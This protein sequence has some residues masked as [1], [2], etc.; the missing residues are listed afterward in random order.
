MSVHVFGI[1]HHGP[2]CARCL[3]GALTALAPDI[4]LIEGPPDAEAVLTLAGHPDMKPPVALLVYPVEAPKD[5][6]FYP[7]AEFSPEWQAIRYAL[8]RKVPVRFID[9]PQSV[10]MAQPE[11][12]E[13][14][15]SAEVDAV[16]Q[17]P[18]ARDPLDLLAEAAGYTDHELWWEHQI[19][20]HEDPTGLF[21]GIREAMQ[22]V[23][24]DGSTKDAL[25]A[26]REAH[27]RSMIRAAIKEGHE[28]IA[29]VCGAWHAPVLVDHGTAKEDA[30][31]LK[32]LGKTKVLATW[33]PWTHSRLSFRSGYGAGVHSPGWYQHL[34]TA[35][36]RAV[37]RWAVEAARLL[38]EEDLDAPPASVMEVIR[39]AETLAALRGLRSP[40]LAE[41]N[42]SAVSILCGGDP[43]RLKLVRERLEV[44]SVLG[45]VP[46]DTP[47]VPL[48]R[49][50]QD[51]QKSLRLK[52]SGEIKAMEL[53]LRN[54]NDRERSRL[55]HRLTILGIRWAVPTA[56]QGRKLG[57]FAEAWELRWM[58]EME[59]SII[60]ASIWG[61]TV[62]AAADHRVRR[63][64][65]EA[66][67]LGELAPVLD[68]ALLAELPRAVE[69]L[70]ARVQEMSAL[71]ADVQHMMESLPPLARA[72]RY[73]NVRQTPT[74]AL[75]SVIGALY[76]RIVVGL[77]GACAALDSEAAAKRLEGLM[78]V[79][80]SLGVL[81]HAE[82]QSEWDELLRRLMEDDAAHGVI[83]GWSC[84]S[85]FERRRIDEGELDRQAGLALS[86]ATP[87][88]DAAAWMEGLLK[89]SGLVLLHQDGVWL[90]LDRFLVRLGDEGFQEM[91]PL[92]RRAFSDFS[93][94]ERRS[95]AEKIKHLRKGTGGGKA[96][97]A[98]ETPIDIERANTVLPVLAKIL[99]VEVPR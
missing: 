83:R 56:V 17:P 69:Q 10:R 23:R 77:P 45:S 53:D 41:L 18:P 86:P 12:N 55:F 34:W 8:A 74:E 52:V 88:L 58:P 35:P 91:L 26:Q 71:G 57:T 90:A 42:E 43:T 20:R 67:D 1:R 73:G 14:G 37:T 72:S 11:A 3:V 16:P 48:Q 22:A 49:D 59:V 61:H 32:G 47:T 28:R 75:L 85:L 62:E 95:M 92:L 24:A 46:S 9:L 87:A 4:V 2:G 81:D 63:L 30:A 29:V 27:M 80:E 68:R 94:P 7:F 13:E 38:R 98:L 76:E 19:E 65:A 78:H 15:E 70:L 89:G 60:E 54:D 40:G 21:D 84:R 6:V 99:G 82:K 79:Q 96:A 93:G 44:G 25:E 66:S 64:G 36:D 39:L 31:I 33:I 50:L 5:A 97:A 51:K